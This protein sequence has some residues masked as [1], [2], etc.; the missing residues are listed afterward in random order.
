M[1]GRHRGEMKAQ[2]CEVQQTR[3]VAASPWVA[4]LRCDFKRAN[5]QHERHCAR[6]HERPVIA[7]CDRG[8]R[9]RCMDGN[10]CDRGER[11]R[12]R[13]IGP[14]VGNA[15]GTQRNGNSQCCERINRVDTGRKPRQKASAAIYSAA[16]MP[17]AVSAARLRT[18]CSPCCKSWTRPTRRKV[19]W[20]TDAAS[21]PASRTNR[22]SCRQ[23]RTW[24]R[25]RMQA[26]P[27][28]TLMDPEAAA[29]QRSRVRPV[30]FSN[31]RA[32]CGR[33]GAGTAAVFVG[34]ARGSAIDDRARAARGCA[35]IEKD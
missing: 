1:H 8:V 6:R 29:S 10:D 7:C 3:R 26:Y 2:Q 31:R 34:L 21:S 22:K 28:Q 32:C 25:I 27:K 30:G 5:R 17:P 11:A 4:L 24:D 35:E 19:W 9:H 18:S 15:Q 33:P 16:Q 14:A 13:R 23:R 12:R 20:H